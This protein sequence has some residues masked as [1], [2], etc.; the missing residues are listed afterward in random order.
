MRSLFLKELTGFFNNITGYLVLIVF[1]L[2][3]G[4]IVWV[5]PGSSVLDYGYAD[6]E[7][8]FSYTP[9]VLVFLIPAITMRMV[10]EERKSGTWE[11][12]M[13]SPLPAAY[14]ILAKYFAAIILIVLALV[15]TLLYYFSVYQLGETVGNIDSAAFFGSYISL[16][17]ICGS[18]AAVGLFSSALTD[19]QIV[20]FVIGV[21]M[22]FLLYVGLASMAALGSGKWALF[23]EEISISYHYES[24]S[25]GVINSQ[26]VYYFI[27]L[28]VSLLMMTWGV[29]VRK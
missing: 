28:T 16:L 7:S 5:F 23:W 27:G 2:S 26:N 1:L 3:I 29:V 18:F 17:M 24:M 4:L 12:L 19:N 9:L 14:V 11:I 8:L 15:P 10:A 25:R 22:C 20:A 21:F 13:T 6:L